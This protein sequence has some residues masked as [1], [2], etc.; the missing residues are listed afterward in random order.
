MKLTIDNKE[1]NYFIINESGKI[2]ETGEEEGFDTFSS[3]LVDLKSIEIG[4]YLKLCFNPYKK[5]K[6]FDLDLARKSK[7]AVIINKK[8]KANWVKLNY[9]TLNCE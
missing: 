5:G 8:V 7:K 3:A 4:K 1:I 6:Y 9:K 2:I